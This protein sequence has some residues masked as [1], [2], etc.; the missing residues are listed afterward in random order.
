M[1]YPANFIRGIPNEN[2]MEEDYPKADLF[3]NFEV[4]PNRSDDY[5]ELSINW[6]DD[7]GALKIIFNQKKGDTEELQF[8]VGGAVIA[9]EDLEALRKKPQICD[10]FK[11]ERNPLPDNTYHG[12]LLLRISASKPIRDMIASNL[13][14]CATKVEKR[15]E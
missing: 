5:K 13:A 15:G 7:K 2:T 11:Y 14:L 3:K 10:K 1:N 4:N 9:T 12:N 8:K 6:A